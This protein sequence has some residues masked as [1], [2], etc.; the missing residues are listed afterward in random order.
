[1]AHFSARFEK[2]PDITGIVVLAENHLK[3]DF[4]PFCSLNPHLTI[5]NI[6]SHH[7]ESFQVISISHHFTR[8]YMDKNLLYHHHVQVI[9]ISDDAMNQHFPPVDRPPPSGGTSGPLASAAFRSKRTMPLGKIGHPR[10]M[11]GATFMEH[12]Q[13]Y[14]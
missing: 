6:I 14:G 10:T 11:H 7:L 12:A 2:N 1:M 13:T 4:G 8:T 5:F 3:S 9:S